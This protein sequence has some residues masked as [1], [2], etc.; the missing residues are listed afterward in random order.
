MID[1]NVAGSVLHTI[2]CFYKL[3]Q[4]YRVLKAT[5]QPQKVETGSKMDRCIIYKNVNFQIFRW[6][7]TKTKKSQWA[8]NCYLLANEH[9]IHYMFCRNFNHSPVGVKKIGMW[10]QYLLKQV[11]VMKL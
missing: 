6:D 1:L 2:L 11:L 3:L 4:V 9:Q 8:N 5:R 10:S 7:R